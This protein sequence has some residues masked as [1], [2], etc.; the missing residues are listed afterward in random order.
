[1]RPGDTAVYRNRYYVLGR[2]RADLGDGVWEILR[3]GRPIERMTVRASALTVT[4]FVFAYGDAFRLDGRIVTVL[5]DDGEH[6]RVAYTHVWE[7]ITKGGETI[8]VEGGE[9]SVPREWARIASQ[10]G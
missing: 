7:L 8:A 6:V 3:D 5:S 2:E 1:M 10:G 4:S 9:S